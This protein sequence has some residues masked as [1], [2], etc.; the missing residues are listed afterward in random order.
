M[1]VKK[2]GMTVMLPTTLLDKAKQDSAK[3]DMSLTAYIKMLIRRV[4]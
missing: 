2:S 4:K 3:R 1:K